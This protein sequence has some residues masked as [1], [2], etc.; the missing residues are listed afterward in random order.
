MRNSGK[1]LKWILVCSFCVGISATASALFTQTAPADLLKTA[2]EML[3]KVVSIRGLEPTGPIQK[4][5]KTRKEIAEYLD[6][7]VRKTYDAGEL[8]SEGTMLQKLGLIPGSMNYKDFMLKLLTEQ[9]G[10]YYDPE[11]KT[12]FIAGW[13]PP[14]EQ[15]PVMVHELTH[16]LQDQHFNL[17]HLMAEDR[18]LHDDDE[19]L[20]HMAFI[21]GDATAVMLDYLLAPAK[22]SFV[23]LPNLAFVM[24]SQYSTMETQFEIFRQAPLYLKETMVFPYA[25]GATF[26]Q[27]V[28]AN[29]PWGAVN[30]I[31]SDLPA[32]TEQ[33]IHP[34]KYLDKRD[35]PLP[36]EA[37]DPASR[38]GSGWKSVYTNVLGEFTIY[39]ML[40]EQVSEAQAKAA[41][42]G[43]G[44]DKVYLLQNQKGDA[45]VWG[46]S[47][48]DTTED[49]NEFYE[50]VGEWLQRRFPK[51]RR[52]DESDSGYALAHS[53]EYDSLKHDGPRV[54]FVIG[55]PESEAS[56][57][58]NQP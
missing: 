33:I 48:W 22:R 29:Q 46:Y 21:E 18:K 34:E 1:R 12:F 57:L 35:N 44:G 25:F 26:L 49:G 19:V 41:S 13:L 47:V 24:R 2:D 15:K 9:V 30:K 6:Q 38:L 32:S 4:G 8:Q 31:Y 56:K 52:V 14:D 7:H 17:E 3:Q 36:V 58:K 54:E 42:A 43:W 45:A 50:A 53:G 55:F 27:K 16:A 51:A 11:Q 20:A 40:K 23:Q 39:L 10:G 37:P 28:R 5:I